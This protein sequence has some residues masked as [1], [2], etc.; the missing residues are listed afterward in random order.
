MFEYQGV[1]Y[2]YRDLNNHAKAQGTTIENLLKLNPEIKERKELLNFDKRGLLDF[3]ENSLLEQGILIPDDV[4]T[5]SE[6]QSIER[7][8]V[9]P[10]PAPGYVGTFTDYQD[11][12]KK[13]VR[14]PKKAVE[15][16]TFDQK[17]AYD[18][19]K[20]IY[21]EALWSERLLDAK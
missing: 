13:I 14:R 1:L 12:T 9:K 5:S 16:L 10:I 18:K 21:N 4:D 19:Y 15:N 6:L 2:T 7:G 11:F 20:K 17:K 8:K 3:T